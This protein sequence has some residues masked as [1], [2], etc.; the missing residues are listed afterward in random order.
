MAYDINLSAA[1]TKIK[2]INFY[3]V[4]NKF[5]KLFD[6]Y[7]IND[8]F[9]FEPSNTTLK[10]F[11]DSNM[12]YNLIKGYTC[13]KGKSS[14]TDLI[15]TNRKFSLKYSQSFETSLSDHYH[16]VYNMLKNAFQKSEPN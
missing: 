7:I 3:K 8:D 4:F 13:F 10:G 2:N 15:L 14:L 16:M 6:N 11:L 9:N 12:L 5:T 1:L